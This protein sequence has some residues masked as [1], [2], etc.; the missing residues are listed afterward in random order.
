MQADDARALVEAALDA[1]WRGDWA[2]HLQWI[3]PTVELSHG[4]AGW[5]P[6]PSPWQRLRGT[7]HDQGQGHGAYTAAMRLIAE[8][9]GQA[10]GHF[11]RHVEGRMYPVDPAAE[12]WEVRVR[13]HGVDSTARPPLMR[14]WHYP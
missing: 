3:A 12:S 7:D 11:R 1:L 10:P 9:V 4:H 14:V 6:R 2:A 13:I 8:G 5:P